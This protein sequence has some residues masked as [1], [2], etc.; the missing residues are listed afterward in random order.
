MSKKNIIKKDWVDPNKVRLTFETDN[1]HMTYEYSG[2]SARAIKRGTD[3]AG[4]MGGRL[5]NHKKKA[6]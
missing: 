5:V 1:G 4:L 3:P 6:E 2:S